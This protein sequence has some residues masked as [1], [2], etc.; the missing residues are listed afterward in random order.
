ML[1]NLEGLTEIIDM[2]DYTA[3]VFEIQQIDFTAE[4][5]TVRLSL[6]D[7]EGSGNSTSM[8]LSISGLKAFSLTEYSHLVYHDIT[9]KHELLRPFQEPHSSLYAKGKPHR[10]KDLAFDLSQAYHAVSGNWQSFNADVLAQLDQANRLFAQ[11]PQPLLQAYAATL[12]AYEVATSII[13]DYTPQ[14]S[15]LK[16]FILDSNY[17]IGTDFAF[18]VEPE[19]DDSK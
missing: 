19:T 6:N 17:F 12:N 3:Y 1:L 13:H 10:F 4:P 14:A 5:V 15:D 8:V 11:G 16:V 2:A 7:I 18:E 9:D